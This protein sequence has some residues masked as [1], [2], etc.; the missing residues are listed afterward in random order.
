[1]EILFGLLFIYILFRFIG[2][3]FEFV[4]DTIHDTGDNLYKGMDE[5]VRVGKI[6]KKKMEQKKESV[7]S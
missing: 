1:M 6:I 5:A 3:W 2:W 7:N 4:G